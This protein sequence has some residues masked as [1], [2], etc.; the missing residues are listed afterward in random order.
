MRGHYEGMEH[1]RKQEMHDAG[2]ITEDHSAVAN[3]P[4]DVKYK[5]WPS[6]HSGMDHMIDDTI[7]G[8][9]RQMQPNLFTA[10]HLTAQF[11]LCKPIELSFSPKP[12]RFL[13]QTLIFR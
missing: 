13:D 4:Q 2:M 7:A 12:I 11:P 1:R 6:A 5:P 9:N 10:D 3:M 8:I